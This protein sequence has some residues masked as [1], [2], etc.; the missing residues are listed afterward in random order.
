MESEGR[1]GES[2]REFVFLP[3]HLPKLFEK[4]GEHYGNNS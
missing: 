3:P 4:R 2:C 1:K